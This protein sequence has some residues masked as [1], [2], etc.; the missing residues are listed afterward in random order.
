MSPSPHVSSTSPSSPSS[1]TSFMESFA[2]IPSTS[3]SLFSSA[4]AST[5]AHFT[6][7]P[8]PF[9]DEDPSL[10]PIAPP[11]PQFQP[12]VAMSTKPSPSPPS[13]IHNT[14]PKRKTQLG[15]LRGLLPAVRRTISRN[16]GLLLIGASQAF[17]ALM[18]V[19]VKLL[20]SS[21]S[22]EDQEESGQ[23]GET[24]IVGALELIIVRMVRLFL[25][26]L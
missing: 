20:S 5:S 8:S 11:R 14:T 13:K 25:I 12:H 3:S 15:R 21:P 2:S 6:S 22:L 7:S 19:A 24:Q 26:V 16:T 10:T 17:F 1:S 9:Q 18:N 4:S 23:E